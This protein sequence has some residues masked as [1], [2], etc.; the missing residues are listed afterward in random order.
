MK[1]PLPW[2]RAHKA[3]AGLLLLI[4]IAVPV[5]VTRLTKSD[6][7]TLTPPLQRGNIV[8]GVYGI[9]TVIANQSFQVHVGVTNIVRDIFVKE[10]D[11][12]KKNQP[13]ISLDGSLVRAPFDGVITSLPSKVGEVVFIQSN[14]LTLTNLLDRFLVVSLEQEGAIRVK[15][16]QKA[17]LSF[18][19][20]RET[21]YDG[22]VQSVYAQ[23]G[24]FLARI[25]IAGLPPQILPGMT[26]DVAIGISEHKNV[27]LAPT[28]ALEAGVVYL[29]E[30][31]GTKKIPVKVGI[32]DGIMAE[33]ISGDL[34]AGDQLLIR[35]KVEP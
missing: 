6:E 28:S 11:S 9:G 27:L 16:G 2:L 14:I 4:F 19:S 22:T 8:E 29:K 33:I 25:D 5:V 3:I 35:K 26:A 1:S 10:G 20:I 31:L 32:T 18:E 15:R 24:N 21:T 12:V 17:R 30:K 7:G 34:K 23:G 13:L